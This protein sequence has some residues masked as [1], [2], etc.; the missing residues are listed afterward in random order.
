MSVSNG[1]KANEDTFNDA[2][3]SKTAE[4]GN[5]V[6]GIVNLKNTSDTSSGDEILNVQKELNLARIKVYS[7]QSL[8]SSGEINIDTEIGNQFRPVQST[9]GAV[10][11]ST[12]P[13]GNSG[14]WRDGTIIYLIGLSDTDYPTLKHDDND[15]GAILNGDTDL[16]RFVM[17]KLIWLSD[18]TR[19]IEVGSNIR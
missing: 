1:A 10:D 19:W 15:Y 2:F 5:D 18:L 3:I 12:T 13:F 11:L 16:K 4:S 6:S 8:A 9:G 7:T 14:G 17:V